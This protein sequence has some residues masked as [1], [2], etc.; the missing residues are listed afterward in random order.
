MGPRKKKE[1]LPPSASTE[2]S[3]VRKTKKDADDYKP[4]DW[5]RCLT[6]SLG[7]KPRKR[8]AAILHAAH[9][10]RENMG[11][12]FAEVQMGSLIWERLE[13]AMDRLLA[14][15][16]LERAPSGM[17]RKAAPRS[18]TKG[19]RAKE[20]E[21][22]TKRRRRVVSLDD[23]DK[24]AFRRRGA[25]KSRVAPERISG[26]A[27][28]VRKNSWEEKYELLLRYVEREGNAFV[29]VKHVENGKRLGLWVSSQR[30][31]RDQI[32]AER[33]TALEKL[34]GWVWRA[35]IMRTWDDWYKVLLIYIKREGHSRVPRDHMEGGC[36][37]GKWVHVQRK[38][39]GD[40]PAKHKAAFE[41]L[42]GWIWSVQDARW[43]EK[44]ELL[45]RYVEREGLVTISR[46][47][48][49]EGQRLGQWVRVQRSSYNRMS[50][51]RKAAL[52]RLPGWTWTSLKDSWKEKYI[53]LQDYVESEG[54]A[55]IPDTYIANGEF[56]GEWADRQRKNREKLSDAHKAALERLPGWTWRERDRRWEAKYELLLGYVAREGHAL[57]RYRHIEDGEMIGAW[58]N[59]QRK[60][61]DK[62][63]ADRKA[64]LERLPGWSWDVLKDSW[65]EKYKLLLQYA[66]R[67]GH[68]LIP[69]KHVE[70]G[71]RLGAWVVQQRG[72]R[73]T[74]S[75]EYKAALE[76]LPGWVWRVPQV[77][78]EEKYELLL[79]YV[80]REGHATVL[81]NHV[82]DGELLGVWIARQ[83]RNRDK[84]SAKR[85]A[86][87]ERLPGWKW[88]KPKASWEEK[89][90]L[91]FQYVE[92]EGHAIVPDKH[93]EN[94]ERIGYW[95]NRQR[96][97]RDKLSAERK[98]ALERLPGWKWSK[99]RISWEEKY[100]LLIRYTE[101]ESHAI[102][103]RKHIEDGERLG[104][105]VASQR[106]N[107]DKL[108]AERKAAL[109]RLPG[110]KW[111]LFS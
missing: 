50:A 94:G 35:Q 47:H 21:P 86:A 107:R 72:K 10:A 28:R 108:S 24:P 46:T 32:S 17:V 103:P 100:A 102:V 95:V 73:D 33:K 91:L 87:L 83:R 22:K 30:K 15:R 40:M 18:S 5:E 106:K 93:V 85:K 98:A 97:N 19:G 101:R 1:P 82:E 92:R 8:P 88:S 7:R 66:E 4:K 37:L 90:E 29:P 16:A 43:K 89:Y 96:R 27:R 64:A 3:L 11:L 78:W 99:P 68:A 55:K 79:Q 38:A 77:S 9:W 23:D 70:N 39:K 109:E 71:I 58:V 67:E 34:P 111:R 104:K 54:H 48:M 75:I 110:W 62:L 51:T 20:Q 74:L 57:V 44:Y 49:E 53:L 56:L 42:P 61:H 63:S 60:H 25:A 84:L 76:R 69:H 36:G 81:H 41:R 14:K 80:E 6:R 59:K 12:E 45:L 26:R 2:A 65:E 31:K 52:E 13:E 105:W